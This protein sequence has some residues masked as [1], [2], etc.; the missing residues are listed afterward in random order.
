MAL[1]IT[2]LGTAS[3]LVEAA[4]ISIAIDPY[5]R[6]GGSGLPPFPLDRMAEVSAIFI[7]HPHLDH[8]ADIARLMK[9]APAP[10]YVCRRGIE[11][12]R[13][14]GIDIARLV[15]VAP[16]DAISV[17]D[18]TVHV[19][20]GRHCRF[21][22]R[23]V[24]R[25]LARCV[26]PRHLGRALGLARL[27]RRFSIDP[28]RDVLAF[29]VASSD[30]SALVFGSAAL[31]AGVAYPQADVLVYPYQGRSDMAAYSL[32]LLRALGIP[33]VVLSHFDDAFPP[34][35]HGMDTDELVCL[36]RRE[37]PEVEIIR[38]RFD[39]TITVGR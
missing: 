12:A 1:H 34:V 24:A 25:T 13:A 4:G 38:P 27:N 5:L 3:L 2:W 7:T 20:R 8:F 21:D 16:G 33:R 11:I 26:H 37:L 28:N 23:L 6:S 30:T 22:A 32:P 39:E 15:E 17:G 31:A 18:L 10:V 14:E 36:A 35:S 19:Y 29:E 9:M